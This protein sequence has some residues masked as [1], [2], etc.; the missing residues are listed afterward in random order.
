MSDGD[1]IRIRHKPNLPKP[2]GRHVNHDPRNREYPVKLPKKLTLPTKTVRHRR[3]GTEVN[4]GDL[5]ACTGYS[6]AHLLN[7]DPIR[8]A[9][10]TTSHDA[11]MRDA[12]GLRFYEKATALDP[13][14]GQ[15][16]P[17][18]TGS[19]GLSVCKVM[20][21]E[22]IISQYQWAFGWAEGMAAISKFAFM[23]GT[24]WL[25]GMFDPDTD[26]RVHTTG[27]VAGGHEYVWL[28][29]EIRSKVTPGKNRS[30]FLN[31]WGS[32]WGVSGYFYMTWDD[33]KALL[34]GQNG[35]LI[36]PVV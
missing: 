7:T 23:Q 2:L 29:V 32:D 33:H 21:A 35:D 8:A 12:D 13:Y 26:G 24:V 1:V 27:S 10:R 5:G 28:G 4:Q 3:Y 19:D 36:R 22:G 14:P 15:Y 31:Q 6:G 9:R 30:W 11:L 34:D 20:Q 18:D 16:P 17:N 25:D